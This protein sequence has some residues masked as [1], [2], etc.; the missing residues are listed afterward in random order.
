MKSS[1]SHMLEK[2]GLCGLATGVFGTYFF[3]LDAMYNFQ[4]MNL[5]VPLLAIT[6]PLGFANS[7]IADGVHSF[8]HQHIPLGKKTQDKTAFITNAVI[9][10]TTFT[11]LMALS[12]NMSSAFGMGGGFIAGA[13]SEVVG[14]AT[15]EYLVNNLYI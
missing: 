1:M 14:S 7:F 8:I 10:G 12:T 2:A 3:G 15:Y 4:Y 6:L 13:F 9:A 5:S 11:A